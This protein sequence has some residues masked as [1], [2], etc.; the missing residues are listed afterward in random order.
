MTGDQDQHIADSLFTDPFPS[1]ERV[2]SARLRQNDRSDVGWPEP[3]REE[4]FAGMAGE[5]VDLADP[6]TEADRTAV[7]AHYI[8][9]FA[10]AVGPGSHMMVGATRHPA[11]IFPV[12]VGRT[13]K[14]R[15]GDS[16]QPALRVFEA[17]DPGL[18]RI[19]GLST[20]EGLV[21]QLRDPIEQQEPVKERGSLVRYKAVVVDEGVR[22]KRLLVLEPELARV[23]KVMSRQGNTL[24]P[25]LRAAWDDGTL[26]VMTKSSPETATGAHIILTGHIT[27]EELRRDLDDVS[28][29]NGFANRLLFLAVDRSKRIPNPQPFAGPAVDGFIHRLRDLLQ[30]AASVG[31]M[32][33]SLEAC[34]LWEQCYDELSADQDGLAGALLARGEAQVLRLSMIYALNEASPTI[35]V[36]HIQ[37]ALALWDYSVRSV[38]HLFAETLGHRVSDALLKAGRLAGQLSRTQMRDHFGRNSHRGEIDRALAEL[39]RQGLAHPSQH[40]TGGRPAEVWKF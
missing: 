39:E 27:L 9:A 15:K 23:L 8:A 3:P 37:S 13:A 32:E 17:A 33:R 36:C 34:D 38:K 6:H 29:A 10:A 11:R 16:S 1:P 40:E 19:D 30:A 25:L 26:R 7:L 5:L 18:R 20:G 2:R 28:I 22:D 21:H 14:S 4:A 31:R 24:S 35:E 12:I